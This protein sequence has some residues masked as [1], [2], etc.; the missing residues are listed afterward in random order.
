MQ[1]VEARVGELH[2]TLE[3]DD[4]KLGAQVPMR[5]GLEIELARGAPAAHLGVVVLVITDRR[6]GA[7]DVGNGIGEAVELFLDGHEGA[8]EIVDLVAHIAHADLGVFGLLGI[9]FLE[10]GADLLGDGIAL[11]L[12]GFDLLDNL[13]ALRVQPA[14]LIVIPFRVAVFQRLLDDFGVLANEANVEHCSSCAW[15]DAPFEM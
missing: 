5:L 1:G 2:A 10:H 14:K 15:R 3:V 7:G 9:A 4:A 8:I 12:E 13:A 11:G 6:V